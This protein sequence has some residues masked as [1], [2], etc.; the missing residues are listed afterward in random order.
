MRQRSRISE[1][2][3]RDEIEICN[4]LLFRS[5]KYLSSYSS[6]AVD[7]DSYRHCVFFLWNE[8]I[9]RRWGAAESHVADRSRSRCKERARRRTERRSGCHYIVEKHW[10]RAAYVLASIGM[11]RKRSGNIA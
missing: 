6:K 1:V 2:V 10:M 5:A 3:D 7:A 4:S 8:P 11:D 9:A